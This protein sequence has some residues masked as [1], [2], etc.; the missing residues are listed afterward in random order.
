MPSS[1][2]PVLEDPSTL[3]I[4][5]DY[6]ALNKTSLS[7]EVSFPFHFIIIDSLCGLPV[8]NFFRFFEGE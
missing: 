1:W 7:K 8:F 4:F 3:Q 2:R 6:Y 5:F